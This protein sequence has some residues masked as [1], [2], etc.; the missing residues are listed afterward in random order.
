MNPSK[1]KLLIAFVIFF[2]ATGLI[3]AQL[4]TPGNGFYDYD[5]NFYPSIILGNGQEWAAKN[6][7]TTKYATGDS[8][9][10]RIN[11]SQWSSTY[12]A[13]CSLNNNSQQDTIYGKLY[14]WHAVNNPNN[15]CQLGWHVPSQPEWNQMVS[16][17]GGNQVA[18]GK[19]KSVGTALWQSPNSD[20][21]NES[22]FSALPAGNRLP[23]GNFQVQ[24]DGAYWWAS[25]LNNVNNAWYNNV[26]YT[27]GQFYESGSIFKYGMSV[28][29]IKDST[30]TGLN[31]N[32]VPFD[33]LVYPNPTQDFL[34]IT[35]NDIKNEI[36]YK[37]QN[38][39][40]TTLL[41]GNLYA[42]TNTINIS[43]LPDGIY[44]IIPGESKG[45]KFVIQK[46]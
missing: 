29:C 43:N 36:G 2:H 35:I 1:D 17:L 15:I 8:I 34:K 18:G 12:P 3:Y 6:L 20:A 27:N 24:G 10:N 4:F 9:P 32:S 45:K 28:R 5:G 14:N 25:D 11:N 13:W 38:S 7:N 42:K 30:S 46:N 44:F 16:F 23:S 22:G 40:G 26:Y 41:S 33:L 39:Y 31:N 21:T 37:I 19:L